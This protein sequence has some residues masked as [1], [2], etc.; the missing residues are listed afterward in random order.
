MEQQIPVLHKV[1]WENISKDDNIYE[2]QKI[3]KNQINKR[4]VKVKII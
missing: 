2:L 3:L 1:I 4:K